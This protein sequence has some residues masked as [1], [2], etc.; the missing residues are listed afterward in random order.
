MLKFFHS[1]THSLTHLKSTPDGVST[2]C[3]N[4]T[5]IHNLYNYTYAKTRIALTPQVLQKTTYT[6]AGWVRLEAEVG[7]LR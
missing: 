6:L 3:K 7:L 1:I 5:A 4:Y 2:N